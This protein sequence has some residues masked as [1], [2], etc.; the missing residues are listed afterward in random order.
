MKIMNRWVPALLEITVSNKR[1][2]NSVKMKPK[3]LIEVDKMSMFKSEIAK[4]YNISKSLLFT[5]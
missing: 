4:D 5:T 1:N 2:A 3:S